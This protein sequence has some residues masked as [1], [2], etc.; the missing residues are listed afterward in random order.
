MS[1]IIDYVSET[2]LKYN[3]SFVHLNTESSSLPVPNSRRH[4]K[5]VDFEW[6]IGDSWW[7]NDSFQRTD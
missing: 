5:S 4:F 3:Y 6:F 7:C 1:F 2:H